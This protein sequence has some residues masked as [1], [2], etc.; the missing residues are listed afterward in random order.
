M[1]AT[2]QFHKRASKVAHRRPRS[3]ISNSEQQLDILNTY[4]VNLS[5]LTSDLTFVKIQN[6]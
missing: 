5:F 2:A 4:S 1:T 3:R 6:M